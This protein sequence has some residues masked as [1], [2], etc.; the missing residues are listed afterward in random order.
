MSLDWGVWLA[1]I[2]I[3]SF[4]KVATMTRPIENVLDDIRYCAD[5]LS[6]EPRMMQHHRKELVA[7]HDKLYEYMFQYPIADN[8][9][10]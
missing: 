10:G 3:V 4:R 9:Q 5:R 6:A 7:M 8:Q 1:V 2:R